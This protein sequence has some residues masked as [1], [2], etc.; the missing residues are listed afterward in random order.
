MKPVLLIALVFANTTLRLPAAPVAEVRLAGK[1]G[2][3]QLLREGK[4]YLIRG[5]GGTGINSLSTIVK[6]L[7]PHHPTM[8]VIAEAGGDKIKNLHRLCPEIDIIGINSYGG[9]ATLGERYKKAGG[10][11]PYVLTEFGPLG[12]W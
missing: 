1:N 8:T 10:T 3:F 6:E 12:I 5:A 7:D 2:T 11:K 9:A 4:P